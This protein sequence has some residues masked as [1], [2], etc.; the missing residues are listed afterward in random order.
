MRPESSLVSTVARRLLPMLPGD[1]RERQYLTF[2]RYATAA[3]FAEYHQITFWDHLILQ[4]VTSEPAACHAVVALAALHKSFEDDNEHVLESKRYCIQQYTKAIVGLN[5]Y[6]SA[7]SCIEVVLVCCILFTS[8]ES[9]R[10]NCITATQHLRSGFKIV[11]YW[12]QNQSGS[13]IIQQE[14]VP[15]FVRLSIQ[16]KSIIGAG[17]FSDD[18]RTKMISVSKLFSNLSEA[19][20]SLYNIMDRMLDVFSG[21]Q[22]AKLESSVPLAEVGIVSEG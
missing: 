9:I 20:N 21:A 12:R 11:S 16:V 4:I 15:I 22:C 8:F 10:G 18:Q 19:R 3:E 17:S 5:T 1:H 2:F 14:L 6:I 13:K 7:H